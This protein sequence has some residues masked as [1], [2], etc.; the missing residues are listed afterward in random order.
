MS[1]TAAKKTGL[2]DFPEKRAP[3]KIKHLLPGLDLA[4]FIFVPRVRA[5]LGERFVELTKRS[6]DSGA[7]IGFDLDREDEK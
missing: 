1:I 6:A 4:Q 7:R 2:V 3:T 5:P